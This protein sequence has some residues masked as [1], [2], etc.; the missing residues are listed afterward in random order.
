MN[1]E[2]RALFAD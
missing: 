2:C 1:N